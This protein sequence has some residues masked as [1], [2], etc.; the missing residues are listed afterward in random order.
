MLFH[1]QSDAT[2]QSDLSVLVEIKVCRNGNPGAVAACPVIGVTAPARLAVGR[3]GVKTPVDDRE[4]TQQADSHVLGHE[5]AERHR[6]RRQLEKLGL[7]E[8][9]AV[10]IRGHEV[11]GQNLLETLHIPLLHRR[12]KVEV[13]GGQRIEIALRVRVR[14]HGYLLG[15]SA[16][17][18]SVTEWS[19]YP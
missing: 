13:Q 9:R 2:R 5:P 11:V 14:L 3:A 17:S 16:F 1:K 10:R 12:E 8:Q 6:L 15:N 19:P 18:R 4:I 7:V